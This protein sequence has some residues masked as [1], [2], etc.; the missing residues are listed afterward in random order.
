MSG[1]PDQR[2]QGLVSMHLYPDALGTYRY[3]LTVSDGC[4]AAAAE[5][6]ATVV[7]DPACG[8]AAGPG[9]VWSLIAL[10]AGLG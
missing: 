2:G 1:A 4:S 7:W 10:L 6:A 3:R 9:P 5:A 8:A